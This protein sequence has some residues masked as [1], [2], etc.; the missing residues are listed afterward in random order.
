MK[1]IRE[2]KMVEQTTVKFVADDGKEFEKDYEC[3]AYEKQKAKELLNAQIKAIMT[4]IEIPVLNWYSKYAY[5]VKVRNYD[6]I[7]NLYAYFDDEWNSFKD[8]ENFFEIGKTVYICVDD[9]GYVAFYKHDL[10]EELKNFGKK[11]TE[12]KTDK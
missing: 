5:K 8:Y 11:K 9:D 6:D 12:K 2:T 1:E 3:R 7:V 10:E 4:E